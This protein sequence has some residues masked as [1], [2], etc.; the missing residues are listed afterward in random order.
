MVDPVRPLRADAEI[1]MTRILEAAEQVFALDPTASLEAVA[2]AAGVARTTVHRR[3][4]SREEL[5]TALVA[6]VNKKLRDA[7][8]SANTE[9]APPLVA[10]YQLTVATLD[11]KVEWRAAWQLMGFRADEGP[12]LDAGVLADLDA[13]LQR[14]SAAGLVRAGVDVRWVRSVYIS[15]IH[16]AATARLD[17]E[18]AATWAHLVMQTLLAGVGNSDHDLQALLSQE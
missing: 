11:L 9:T 7:L 1:S 15:L 18:P 10:L 17:D 2:K 13:L 5:R 12:G 16:E 3:F 4:S 6:V 14:S 8:D